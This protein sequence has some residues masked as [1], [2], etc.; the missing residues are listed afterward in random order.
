MKAEPVNPQATRLI[1]RAIIEEW[2]NANREN[3]ELNPNDLG[4]AI[5][6]LVRGGTLGPLEV[7]VITD[8]VRSEHDAQGNKVKFIW[9]CIPAPEDIQG[10]LEGSDYVEV[11]SN[12]NLVPVD[13]EAQKLGEAVLFGCGR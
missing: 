11:D 12:G 4:N 3:R 10:W 9:V 5:R 6:G 2:I 1:G 8:P 13:Q 7:G